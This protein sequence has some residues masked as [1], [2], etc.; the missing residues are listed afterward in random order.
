[1]KIEDFSEQRTLV[2]VACRKKQRLR[3]E[4]KTKSIIIHKKLK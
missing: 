1:M 3:Q 2:S 4:K